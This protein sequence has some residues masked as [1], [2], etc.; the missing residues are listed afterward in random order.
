MRSHLGIVRR[1][2]IA[3]AFV[4]YRASG[5]DDMTHI[6]AGLDDASPSTANDLCGTKGDDNLQ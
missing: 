6:E 2:V 3:G 4:A 5:H 1:A